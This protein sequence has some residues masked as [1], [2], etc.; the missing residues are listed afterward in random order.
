[1]QIE[2][3][4]DTSLGAMLGDYISVS[5]VR[6][7][8]VPVLALADPPS[9]AG[10]SESIFTCRLQAPAPRSQTR[11]SSPCRRPSP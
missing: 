7:Q 6:G 1:M 5:Y 4:A 10:H 9:A 2:W 11:V 8:P 3:L